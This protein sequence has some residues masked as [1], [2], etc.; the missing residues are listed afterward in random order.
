MPKHENLRNNEHLTRINSWEGV[1]FFLLVRLNKK[2]ETHSQ[3]TL[4]VL[5]LYKRMLTL[6]FPLNI[7]KDYR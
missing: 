7:D 3:V 1:L 4:G 5:Q 2:R 6:I